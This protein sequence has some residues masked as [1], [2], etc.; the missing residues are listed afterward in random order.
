M[1]KEE[2]EEFGIP[3]IDFSN[4]SK[5]LTDK[6]ATDLYMKIKNEPEPDWRA[7]V[8]HIEKHPEALISWDMDISFDEFARKVKAGEYD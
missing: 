7:F 4:L 8:E 1:T 6:E 2:R 5:P 3:E